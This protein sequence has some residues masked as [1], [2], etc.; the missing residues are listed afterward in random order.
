LL[1]V[2]LLAAGLTAAV[3]LLTLQPLDLTLVEIRLDPGSFVSKM[4]PAAFALGI[5]AWVRHELARRPVT[6]AIASSGL[7]RWDTKLFA[8][9]GVAFAAMG[10]ILLWL[11]LHGQSADLAESLAAQQMGPQY[12]YQLTWISRDRS[13]HG[14]S[15]S[16]VVTAWNDHEIKTLL[17][18]WQ[19]K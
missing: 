5:L 10:G 3:V 8:R 15:V 9:A 4:V 12:R 2:F 1:S 14:T 13:E 7:R 11:A 16:G 19:T 17:I 6:D 18:H